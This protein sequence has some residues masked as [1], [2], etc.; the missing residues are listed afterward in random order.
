MRVELKMRGEKGET[1]S[2]IAAP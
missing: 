1:C 2:S